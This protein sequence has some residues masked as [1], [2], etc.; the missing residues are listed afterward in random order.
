MWF[1]LFLIIIFPLALSLSS[2]SSYSSPTPN[3]ILLLLLICG[4]TSPLML[5][6]SLTGMVFAEPL[7]GSKRPLWTLK[8]WT[9][10]YAYCKLTDT[11]FASLDVR[12]LVLFLSS[13]VQICGLE[14]PLHC[15]HW[16]CYKLSVSCWSFPSPC[17]YMWSF[18]FYSTGF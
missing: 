6:Q 2:L 9:K 16:I 13:K 17:L 11:G 1:C 8:N 12:A 14:G 4:H 18:R 15:L 3:Q 7:L 10:L 5:F